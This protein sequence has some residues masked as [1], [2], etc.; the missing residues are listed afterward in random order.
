M[1]KAVSILISIIMAVCMCA[2]LAACGNNEE[3]PTKRIIGLDSEKTYVK[4]K[5][6][7]ENQYA[8]HEKSMYLE[9]LSYDKIEKDE[10]EAITF[11]ISHHYEIP[12]VGS[13]PQKI[14]T[15]LRADNFE[16]K[17][18]ES[19]WADGCYHYYVYMNL[20][21]DKMLDGFKIDSINMT[22][23]GRVYKFSSEIIFQ[24]RSNPVYISPN[25]FDNTVGDPVKGADSIL[26]NTRY[27][28]TLKSLKYQTEGYEIISYYVQKFEGYTSD[29]KPKDGEKISESLPI[30][31]KKDQTYQ[32]FVEAVVPD[33]CLYYSNRFEAI[34]EI[35]GVEIFY[36]DIESIGEWNFKGSAI[37]SDFDEEEYE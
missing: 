29:G 15:E 30:E 14:I 34:V 3:P 4:G 27:D 7:L 18:G 8:F 6:Y 19:K 12:T 33:D 32:I 1:K 9:V 10:L 16:L 37:S 11:D 22:I 35:Q 13:E 2:P 17:F 28:M 21:A 25:T 20:T 23:A 31:L 24:L 5:F 36:S 26:I